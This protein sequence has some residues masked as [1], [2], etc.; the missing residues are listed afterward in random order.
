MRD[1][2]VA[3]SAEALAQEPW[4]RLKDL[5]GS[6]LNITAEALAVKWPRLHVEGWPDVVYVQFRSWSRSSTKTYPVK[7]DYVPCPMARKRPLEDTRDA[8]RRQPTAGR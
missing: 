7:L 8:A 2:R 6:P 3:L 1:Y 4:Q 5:S